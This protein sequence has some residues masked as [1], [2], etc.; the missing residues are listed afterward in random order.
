MKWEEV[1]KSSKTIITISTYKE[2]KWF[3]S[4]V[5]KNKKTITIFPFYRKL[6]GQKIV[7]HQMMLGFIPILCISE[8]SISY[9]HT[10]YT[11]WTPSVEDFIADDWE[12]DSVPSYI[13]TI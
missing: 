4:I 8:R 3:C 6:W 10:T 9:D 12:I 5:T 11:Q 7:I 2:N 1:I 13:S